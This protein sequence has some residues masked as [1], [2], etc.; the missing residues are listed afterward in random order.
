MRLGAGWP[1][2]PFTPADVTTAGSDA[3]LLRFSRTSSVPPPGP[4]RPR[5]D[6]GRQRPVG[7]RIWPLNCNDAIV[8][9]PNRQD[10]GEA[11]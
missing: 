10:T 5:I 7:D 2:E 1:V 3:A 11:V 6:A 9:E 8:V 4:H